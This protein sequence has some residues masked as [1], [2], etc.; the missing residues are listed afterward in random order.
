MPYFEGRIAA[1]VKYVCLCACGM[2][3]FWVNGATAQTRKSHA[4]GTHVHTRAAAT[5]SPAIIDGSV[6]PEPISDQEAIT[7]FWISIMEPPTAGDPER[8]RFSAKIGKMNLDDND[9]ASVWGAAQGF[10][11][12]FTPY[13]AQA[14]QLATAASSPG[15]PASSLADVTQKRIAVAM[16]IDRLAMTAHNDVLASLSTK[17]AAGLKAQIADVKAH[18]KIV[19]PPKM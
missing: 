14:Q 5:A 19:P 7:V 15:T 8:A 17:G 10:H 16:A 18:M 12:Q 11:E 4:Q 2:A 9:K 3:V 6:H 13:L 1:T